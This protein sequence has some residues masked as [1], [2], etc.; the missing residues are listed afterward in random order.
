MRLDRL[1]RGRP[2]VKFYTATAGV[3]ETYPVVPAHKVIPDWWKEM[4]HE[5]GG[6]GSPFGVLPSTIRRCPAVL[7]VLTTGWIVPLWTDIVVIEDGGKVADLATPPGV[8]IISVHLAPQRKGM[9]MYPDE[10]AMAVKLDGIWTVTTPPG[11]SL[12]VDPVPYEV[13]APLVAIP[14]L[15]HTD[16]HHQFNPVFRY[17]LQGDGRHVIAAGMPLCHLTVVYRSDQKATVS[18]ARDDERFADLL[19]RGRGGIGLTGARLALHAYRD[20]VRA[21]HSQSDSKP[22]S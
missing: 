14:G 12:R 4:S 20:Y 11:Y 19:W 18:C 9:P 2:E 6:T 8:P 5:T 16:I 10:D 7:D 21:R 17:R 22:S 15:I 13:D 3:A 1:R